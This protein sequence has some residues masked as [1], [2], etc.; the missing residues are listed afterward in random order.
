MKKIFLLTT[1]IA[2]S[3]LLNAAHVPSYN[4][5]L[6]KRSLENQ[7]KEEKTNR[8]L[9]ADRVAKNLINPPC[10]CVLLT[11][12]K[13]FADNRYSH[14]STSN[15]PATLEDSR[16]IVACAE[17]VLDQSSSQ[18]PDDILSAIDLHRSKCASAIAHLLEKNDVLAGG[19]IKRHKWWN[20]SHTDIYLHSMQNKALHS[21]DKKARPVIL[22]RIREL[23]DTSNR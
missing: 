17:M 13:I 4:Q 7:A 22:Q 12:E 23:F 5:L 19:N 3:S 20:D 15:K 6:D 8:Y 1:L 21:G 14:L 11:L 16:K 2:S 9:H 10:E 18:M